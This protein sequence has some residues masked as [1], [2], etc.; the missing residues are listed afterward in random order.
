MFL[1]VRVWSSSGPR[2][3]YSQIISVDNSNIPEIN[4]IRVVIL[5]GENSLKARGINADYEIR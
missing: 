5:V 3:K 4:T 2:K 1:K